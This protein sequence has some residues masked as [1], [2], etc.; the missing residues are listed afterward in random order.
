MNQA[1]H[2][3]KHDKNI[4]YFVSFVDEMVADS[5]KDES[6]KYVI[7]NLADSF[8]KSLLDFYET[9]QFTCVVG[10][11]YQK[12]GWI[13]YYQGNFR[14]AEKMFLYAII[15][16]KDCKHCVQELLESYLGLTKAYISGNKIKKAKKTF[17]IA[18]NCMLVNNCAFIEEEIDSLV[19]TLGI[20]GDDLLRKR[21]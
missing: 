3:T 9:E 14:K 4:K 21:K 12:L 20:S 18:Y 17:I 10:Y 11:V 5:E 15:N 8:L 16:L 13:K 2:D 1:L 7:L 6:N 19:T